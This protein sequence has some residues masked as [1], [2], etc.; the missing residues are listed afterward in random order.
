MGEV[1]L[2]HPSIV[3]RIVDGRL[4]PYVRE[5]TRAIR[6]Q[7]LDTAYFPFGVVYLSKV[8]SLRQTK[9]FYPKR[10]VPIMIERWQDYEIDDIYDFVCVG[11]I[12]DYRQ[13]EKTT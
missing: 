12:L 3:K 13:K 10:T 11:A 9:S 7:D 6:R 8:S 1:H 2:E 5:D 4:E